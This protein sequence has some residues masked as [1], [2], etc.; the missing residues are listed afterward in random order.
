MVSEQLGT[1]ALC[2]A[3]ASPAAIS[4]LSCESGVISGKTSLWFETTFLLTR[5]GARARRLDAMVKGSAGSPL[6]GARP[7]SI[8]DGVGRLHPIHRAAVARGSFPCDRASDADPETESGGNGSVRLTIDNRFAGRF[9]S[10][11]RKNFCLRR[12]VKALQSQSAQV[13]PAASQVLIVVVVRRTGRRIYIRR[14]QFFFARFSM[15]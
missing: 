9:F 8:G 15:S 10:M 6:S 14:R 4:G 7:H 12:Q 2:A 5:G 13:P 1:F 3:A 11:S